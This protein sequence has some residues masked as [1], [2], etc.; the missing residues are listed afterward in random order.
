MS[1]VGTDFILDQYGQAVDEIVAHCDGDLWSAL[2]ALM[3]V[4][5]QLEQRLLLMS[6]EVGDQLCRHPPQKRVH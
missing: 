5:E 4:N 6:A 1:H 3:L 2:R